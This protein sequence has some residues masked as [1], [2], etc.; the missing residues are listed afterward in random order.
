MGLLDIF[1]P[2]NR[3]DAAKTAYSP[4]FSTITEYAPAFSTW[5]GML[6]EDA[7][8]RATIEKTAVLASKLKPEVLGDSA[9][10]I[11]RAVDTAPNSYMSWPSMLRRLM[12][13]LLMD[14]TVAVVPSL[15]SNMNVIGLFPLKFSDAD[16]VD[17]N[18]EPWVRFYLTGTTEP[19][20]IELRNVCLI[21]R[22]QYD[23]D[24]FG[25]SNGALDQTMSLMNYQNQAQESAIKNGATIRFI[26]ATNSSMRP[27]DIKKKRDE[28]SELNLSEKN[29]SGLLVYDNTFDSLKQ[30]ENYSYTVDTDEMNRI[31]DNVFNYFGMNRD[32][33]QS[34]YTGDQFAAF[35]ESQIEPF[36]VQLGEGLSQM[37][38]TVTQRRHGNAIMFSSNRLE[39]A[40]NA[41]KRN[42]VRDMTDRGI[43]SI[44]EAREILQ[45]PPIEGGNVFIQRGEYV[46]LDDK[47]NILA[48]TG[49][50]ETDGAS[51]SILE[52]PGSTQKDKDRDPGGDDQEY[53]LNDARG[54]LETDD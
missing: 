52:Q 38:F 40:S 4:N 19:L 51:K 43:M 36:A 21:T 47:G 29:K 13:V 11:A 22:F 20:A 16:I 46:T 45:L 9:P 30:V 42:M 23:S 6:Y 44:N 48:R 32:I 15:D 26:A 33:L 27:E 35:Y 39:Y 50:R 1:R 54:G 18:G 7:L 12:T 53:V 25:S 34:D 37:L 3:V 24:F 2:K 31:Q 10:R 14:N 5:N 49:G 28:F 8:V 41:E 17:Y